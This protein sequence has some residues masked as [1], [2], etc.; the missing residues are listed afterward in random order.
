[1]VDSWGYKDIF[2]S[3][4]FRLTFVLY[5][6]D[7]CKFLKTSGLLIKTCM[8]YSQ[9]NSVNVWW[10]SSFLW[11]I[12]F[13]VS[14]PTV[15]NF[16]SKTVSEN[17]FNDLLSNIQ[18]LLFWPCM[19]MFYDGLVWWPYMGFSSSFLLLVFSRLQTI[20]LY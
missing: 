10:F 6:S 1:M 3:K 16:I 15:S 7:N 18:P 8:L 5:L 19:M 14:I 2:S 20:Y 4:L 17:L 12:S 11:E 13:E 9:V